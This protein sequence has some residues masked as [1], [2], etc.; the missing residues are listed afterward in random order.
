MDYTQ[1]IPAFLTAAMVLTAITNIIVQVLKGATKNL[2]PT[3]ALAVVVALAVTVTT[4]LALCSS[5]GIPVYW[6]TIAG[7]IGLGFA[8][9]YAAMFGFD[10]LKE[11]LATIKK[12]I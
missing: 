7:A 4:Y 11:T 10:K 3:N 5:R 8:V 2:I 9:A 6:Y 12:Q 1:Y